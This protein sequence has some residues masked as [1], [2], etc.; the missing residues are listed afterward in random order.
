MA[1][2]QNIAVDEDALVQLAHRVLVGERQPPETEVN[3]LLVD[4][5]A[6]SDL[7][8]RFMGEPGPTDVLAFPLDEEEEAG[9]GWPPGRF[10][11]AP[12]EPYLLGDVVI[13][14]A[15]AADQAAVAG[16]TLEREVSLLLVH[17]LLHLVGYDHADSHDAARMQERQ[18][19]Y[20]GDLMPDDPPR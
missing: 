11:D 8:E 20:L 18:A 10:A 16:S 9:P 14:P 5:Q 1:S 3:V 17:G 7:H 15:V 19:Y 4:R 12:E 6:M 2:E 13:C